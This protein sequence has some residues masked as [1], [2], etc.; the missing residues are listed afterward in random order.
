MRNVSEKKI[1]VEIITQTVS[2][3]FFSSENRVVYFIV[4]KYTAEPGRPQ[5][6]VWRM[7][8]ASWVCKATSTDSEYVICIAF[9]IPTMVYECTSTLYLCFSFL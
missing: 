5:I 1:V 7:R 6:T 2:S 8:I 4:W 9:S 3:N